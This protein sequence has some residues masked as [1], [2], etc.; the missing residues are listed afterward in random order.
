M[1]Q[2]ELFKGKD[3]QFYFRLRADNGEPILASESRGLALR[4]ESNPCEKTRRT[5]QDSH[6]TPLQMGNSSSRYS[7]EITKLSERAKCTVQKPPGK[8]ELQP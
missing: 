2:F 1:A 5:I 7:P 4:M 6:A 8:T 3:E